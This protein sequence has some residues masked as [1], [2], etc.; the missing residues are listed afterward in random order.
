MALSEGVPLDQLDS[1][2]VSELQ[3]L[4]LR[5][6]Y[7]P[8][9][10]DGILG[11]N[12]RSAYSRFIT[13]NGY[14]ARGANTVV[15]L[16]A[17][18]WANA[19]PELWEGVR[20]GGEVNAA[21][22]SGGQGAPLPQV[23]TVGTP[24]V[25]SAAPTSAPASGGSPAPSTSYTPP[26]DAATE[27]QVRKDFPHLAYLMDNPEVRDVLLKAAAGGWDLTTLQGELWKTGWWQTTSSNMR[28]WD[29]KFAQD[30]ATAMLEWDQRTVSIS[31]LT[32]QLG[33]TLSNEDTKWIAG[34]VLREGWSDEQLKRF[35]G[36]L[37]R[38][39]GLGAGQISD[40]AASFKAL[41]RS[42]LS[43][44]S[45]QQAQE[46]AIRVAEGSISREGVES[47]LRSEAKSRFSWLAPQIDSGMTPEDLFGSTRNAVAQMLEVD[48]NQID[49]N[50][51]KWSIITAPV[52]EGNSM[53][54]MNFYEA[55]RW[56]RQRPE[57]RMTDN[58]NQAA[59][60]IGLDLLKTMGVV[61]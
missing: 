13:K 10:V 23:S 38:Q 6:G 11:P 32:S 2:Q 28:L 34:K 54:S 35:L 8:G 9:P 50:D 18:L 16:A 58:A 60:Q 30:N 17:D 49:L 19:L 55:Q 47:L 25:T 24:G 59:S 33:F 7:N 20:Y 36:Q 14:D 45:D 3:N 40:Q 46:F 44:M 12:T 15:K 31:N 5:A 41:A 52:M 57:W 43:T 48:P 56:A 27:E 39:N 51:P 4:L 53:R 37:A 1:Q 29:Q 21:A 26:P 61:A 42:Y 22:T